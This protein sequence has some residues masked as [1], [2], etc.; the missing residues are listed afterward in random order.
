MRTLSFLMLAALAGCTTTQALNAAPQNYRLKGDDTPVLIEG[1]GTHKIVQGA[2]SGH[3]DTTIN[4]N[5]NGQTLITGKLDQQLT[6]EFT[7]LPFNGKPT[8]ASCS[9]KPVSEK[10]AETR[11][12]VF[13]DNE[14]TVTLTF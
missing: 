5:F 2:L 9:T 13:V 12:I 10:M 11:C 4:I 8:A 6:G 3:Y 1:F 7:G 14:R